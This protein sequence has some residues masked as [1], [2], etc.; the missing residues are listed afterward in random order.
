VARCMS[1]REVLGGFC[2]GLGP[3]PSLA[4]SPIL[5]FPN[6]PTYI[7]GP[8]IVNKPQLPCR[9][10]GGSGRVLTFGLF[11]WLSAFRGRARGG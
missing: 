2:G 4:T 5:P 1:F 10:L 7:Y 6:L 9:L 3:T 8:P 11:G